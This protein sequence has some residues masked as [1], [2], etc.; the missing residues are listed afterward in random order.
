MSPIAGSEMDRVARMAD[1]H[2]D[3]VVGSR[4]SVVEPALA[5]ARIGDRDQSAV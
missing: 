2:V 3:P 1:S 5:D 4:D